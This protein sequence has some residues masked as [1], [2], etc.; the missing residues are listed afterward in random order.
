[1]EAAMAQLDREGLFGTGRARLDV[2]INVEVMP[3]DWTNTVR[4]KRLNPPG[5]LHEWLDEVA[6]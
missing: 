3:P 4:A 5:A 6:E 2:V 1:M